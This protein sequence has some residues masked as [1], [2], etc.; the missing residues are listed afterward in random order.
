MTPTPMMLLVRFRSRLSFDELMEIAEQRSPEFEAIPGL[1]QKY[2]VEDV[3]TGEVGG[4]YIWESAEALAE[5][6]K[7][8]LRATIGAA[9]Q[10]EGEPRIDVYRVAKILR[11]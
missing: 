4:C 8:Q 10:V 6:Q 7:S 9:Y 2:Y 1:I 3:E 5:Y 11:D